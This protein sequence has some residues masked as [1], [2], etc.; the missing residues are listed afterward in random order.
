[1]VWKREGG[2]GEGEGQGGDKGGLACIW[3]SGMWQQH[4]VTQCQKGQSRTL[5]HLSAS[6]HNCLLA[7]GQ[8]CIPHSPNSNKNYITRLETFL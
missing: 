4:P 8:P 1:M 7:L 5:L 3:H 6:Q 2:G